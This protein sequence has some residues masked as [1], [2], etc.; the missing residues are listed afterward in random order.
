MKPKSLRRGAVLAAMLLIAGSIVPVVYWLHP[1]LRLDNLH[2][3]CYPGLEWGMTMEETREALG[4]EEEHFRETHQF[5]NEVYTERVVAVR[6]QEFLGEEVQVNFRFIQF[7]DSDKPRLTGMII[8]SRMMGHDAST[9][10]TSEE[11]FGR[12]ENWLKE[13]GAEYTVRTENFKEEPGE[14]KGFYVG[15]SDSHY[16]EIEGKPLFIT[17]YFESRADMRDQPKR[18]Q[19]SFNEIYNWQVGMELRDPPE[20]WSIENL[21]DL[22]DGG[23]KLPLVTLEASYFYPSEEMEKGA[24]GGVLINAWELAYLVAQSKK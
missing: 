10:E 18:Y 20:G 17:A 5:E 4:I 2:T 1:S 22:R 11:Y 6:R 21:Y 15:D 23:V 24:H 13:Q 8:S 14:Y 7:S 19:K 16:D 3:F 12:L 9:D